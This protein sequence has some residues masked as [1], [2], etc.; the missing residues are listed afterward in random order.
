MNNLEQDAEQAMSGGG[1]GG[2]GGNMMGGG[3]QQQ[4]GSSGIDKEVNTGTFLCSWG[5]RCEMWI[6]GLTV[7]LIGM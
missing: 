4:G 5:W 6:G 7:G 1:G 2:G 3:N